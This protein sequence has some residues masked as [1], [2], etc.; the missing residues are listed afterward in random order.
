MELGGL[1]VPQGLHRLDRL[2]SLAPAMCKIAPHDL[3][4]FVEPSCANAEEKP[5]TRKIVEGCHLFG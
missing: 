4:L 2:S 1:L 3:G 5:P